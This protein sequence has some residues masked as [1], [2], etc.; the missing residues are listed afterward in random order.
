MAMDVNFKVLIYHTLKRN[1]MDMQEK[2]IFHKYLQ[3]Q[4]NHFFK[5]ILLALRKIIVDNIS[6]LSLVLR[7]LFNNFNILN[8]LSTLTWVGGRLNKTRA[9]SLSRGG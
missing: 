2:N 5:A 8:V 6:S 3:K 9:T 4:N 7:S 1:N